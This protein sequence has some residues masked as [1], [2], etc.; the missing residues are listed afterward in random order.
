MCA[1]LHGK[2]SRADFR[3]LGLTPTPGLSSN[4]TVLRMAVQTEAFLH[5]TKHGWPQLTIPCL[6]NLPQIYSWQHETLEALRGRLEARVACTTLKVSA[7]QID[8]KSLE[9]GGR[10]EKP[11][12]S[13]CQDCWGR[14]PRGLSHSA[15]GIGSGPTLTSDQRLRA[16]FG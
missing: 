13:G 3:P 10:F 1:K 2:V 12:T 16:P 15:G 11:L 14:L 7:W 6:S 5:H 4:P 9:G 8:F